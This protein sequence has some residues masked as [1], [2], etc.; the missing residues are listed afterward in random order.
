MSDIREISI[1]IPVLNEEDSIE[2][3][4]NKI[5]SELSNINKEIIFVN[6]GSIDDS[7]NRINNII[8]QDS[9]VKMIN[10]L[11]NYGKATALSEAFKIASGKIVITIDADGQNDPKDNPLL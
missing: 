6:D 7:Y 5:V 1:I 8:N 9:D 10:F 3:L 2:P 4:Y 11:K